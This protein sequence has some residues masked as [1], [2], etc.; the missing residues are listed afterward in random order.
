[1]EAS[2][3]KQSRRKRHG[4]DAAMQAGPEARK[5]Q[6]CSED[7]SGEVE[8]E[9]KKTDRQQYLLCVGYI[10]GENQWL[11]PTYSQSLSYKV[12]VAILR[13]SWGRSGMYPACLMCKTNRKTV[14]A[15]HHQCVT[16]MWIAPF[17]DGNER[18]EGGTSRS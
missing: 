3:G 7:R 8:V 12:P 16:A 14:G 2:A 17:S 15:S 13:R 5:T 4:S 6:R 10:Y 1:M 18:R 11:L 9:K